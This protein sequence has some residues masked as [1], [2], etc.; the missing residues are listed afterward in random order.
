MEF[1]LVA[2]LCVL[3]LIGILAIIN[4]IEVGICS[5][6]NKPTIL[7]IPVGEHCDDVEILVNGAIAQ[8][9]QISFSSNPQIVV[10]DLGMSK[11]AKKVV[12]LKSADCENIV[13]LTPEQLKNYLYYSKI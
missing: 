6:K 8:A 9:K 3:S 10:V 4:V 11:E 1:I 2:I 13:L 7:L 12:D 5:S